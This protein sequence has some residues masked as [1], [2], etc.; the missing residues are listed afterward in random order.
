MTEA[1]G[2]LAFPPTP[3]GT[4]KLQ[5]LFD[6]VAAACVGQSKARRG[7][8]IKRSGQCELDYLSQPGVGGNMLEFDMPGISIPTF[9]AGDVA[10]ALQSVPAAV[11]VAFIAYVIGNGKVSDSKAPQVPASNVVVSSTTSLVP[12]TTNDDNPDSLYTADNAVYQEIAQAVLARISADAS[13]E[14][15]LFGTAPTPTALPQA[16]CDKSSVTNVESSVIQRY[17][18]AEIAW[19]HCVNLPLTSR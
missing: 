9:A 19:N 18:C 7:A 12:T 8:N 16:V 17:A 14:S 3:D 10:V 2:D 1:N 15:E 11:A 4:P 6:E 5:S 13:I